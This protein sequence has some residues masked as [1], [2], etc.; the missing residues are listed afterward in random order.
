M[1]FADSFQE[2]YNKT[3][4]VAA[5]GVA[6]I[7]KQTLKDKQDSA[8]KKHQAETIN[9]AIIALAAQ[10]GDQKSL[11]D[12]AKVVDAIGSKDPEASK[13]VFSSIQDKIK[14]K[15]TQDSQ[16]QSFMLRNGMQPT[17]ENDVNNFNKAT[18]EDRI[19]QSMGQA[20][21]PP[22][23]PTV[24]NG[25]SYSPIQGLSTAGTRAL[26]KERARVSN[27]KDIAEGIKTGLQPPELTGL[28]RDGSAGLVR[29]EL[30][31]QGVN[32]TKLTEDWVA[33]KAFAKNLNST[34]QIRLNQALTSVDMS[35][36]PLKELSK[37]VDRVGFV[38]ANSLIVKAGLGGVTLNTDKLKPNQ[39]E[40][41]T[42]YVTQIN[43]MRDE[44]AQG[45]MAGGQPTEKAL[46]LTDAILRPAYGK[47]Q[48]NAALDQ[49]RFNLGVRKN[50]ISSS[51][52]QMIGGNQN[53]NQPPS[54]D[55]KTQKLQQNSKGEYRVVPK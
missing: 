54:Y 36:D 46:E 23:K 16:Q 51:Q 24:V 20:S 50:A 31:R 32:L 8:D 19:A 55:S 21:A 3:S 52:P 42:K 25:Q 9:H 44:L 4:P 39:V 35:I 47:G 37:Q 10:S 29:G 13:L 45:F 5:A 34:Q 12:A 38:P 18:V 28:G 14:A 6:D 41:A 33:T 22:E 30:Q 48:L 7:I 27:A 40:A 17:T 15:A 2:A 49:V 43:L 26:D 11:L 1:G 53:T